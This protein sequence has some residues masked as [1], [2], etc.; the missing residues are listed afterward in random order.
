MVRFEMKSVRPT[1]NAPEQ[2]NEILVK[3]S[4]PL[5]LVFTLADPPSH[6]SR[7]RLC[8]STS[9]KMRWTS[10]RRSA[11]S[12]FL[13]PADLQLSL[14]PS[15]VDHSFVR[16]HSTSSNFEFLTLYAERFEILPVKIKLDYKPKRVDYHALRRGELAE[17]MNFFHFDGSEMTLRHLVLTGVRIRL[18][19]QVDQV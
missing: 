3:V 7:S 1:G 2:S 19:R 16:S 8:D 11:L 13:S 14:L 17:M 4:H 12:T 9:I 6:S 18:T 15:R 5:T 10:S